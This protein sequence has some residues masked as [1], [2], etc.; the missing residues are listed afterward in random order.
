MLFTD[1]LQNGVFGRVVGTFT[2]SSIRSVACRMHTSWYSCTQA[3]SWTVDDYDSVVSARLPDA[4]AEPELY[5]IVTR[6]LI[7]GPC[8][9]FNP[10]LHPAWRTAVREAFPQGFGNATVDTGDRYPLYCRPDDGRR[11]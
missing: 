5:S 2:S 4:G 6:N 7:H 9:I 3:T 1:L 11:F 8:G 10:S